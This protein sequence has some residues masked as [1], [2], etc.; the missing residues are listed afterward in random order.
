MQCTALAMGGALATNSI[1]N[2]LAKPYQAGGPQMSRTVLP[3][4]RGFN[5]LDL[6]STS[7]RWNEFFPM[8]DGK[9]SEDDFRWMS[10]WGFDFVRIP[11]SYLYFIADASRYKLLESRLAQVDRVV[12]LGKKYGV[13]VSLSFHRGPGYCITS[14]PFDQ[15][16]PGNLWKDKEPLDIFEHYWATLAERYRG[17]PSKYVSFDLINEPPLIS[18]VMSRADHERVHRQTVKAIRDKDPE[19]LAIVEGMNIATSPAPELKDL[20][21]VAQST[22]AYLP[23]QLTHYRCPWAPEMIKEPVWPGL[24]TGIGDSAMASSLFPPDV[25]PTA[26]EIFGGSAPWTKERLEKLYAPWVELARQGVGVHCGEMGCYIHT[27][28]KVVLAWF[29]DVLDIFKQHHIGYALW[30]FR[31]P[32]GIVDSGRPDVAYENWRGHKLDRKLLALLQSH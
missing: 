20:P 15:P 17:T 22:R 16:E 18:K 1:V 9:F 4:W 32:F 14:Y 6:F 25:D 7:S 31:G 30:N 12:E 26:I 24:E 13:H 3:R 5:L 21:L 19:R 8:D 27:P 29:T 23:I 28:H 2:G 10:E 11:M